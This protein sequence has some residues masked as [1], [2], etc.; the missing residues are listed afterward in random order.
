MFDALRGHLTCLKVLLQVQFILVAT[1]VSSTLASSLS[2][3]DTDAV[4]DLLVEWFRKY[5]TTNLD[6][7]LFTK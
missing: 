2:D 7:M 4:P 6:L 1:I 3:L 5:R